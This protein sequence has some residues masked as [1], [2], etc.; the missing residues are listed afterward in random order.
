MAQEIINIGTAAG[1]GLDRIG[2]G[3][4]SI[5]RASIRGGKDRR[6]RQEHHGDD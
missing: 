5:I 2:V 3:A 1:A 6:A 4:A